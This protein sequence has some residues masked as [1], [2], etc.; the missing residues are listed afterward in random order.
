MKTILYRI[1]DKY[2]PGCRVTKPFHAQVQYEYKGG[3]LAIYDVAFSESCL[4]YISNMS[5]LIKQIRE[6]IIEDES[7][8]CHVNS[9][10]MQAIAPHI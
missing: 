6:R 7:R 3:V 2:F 10:I 1:P 9:T 4:Q 5:G 8:N